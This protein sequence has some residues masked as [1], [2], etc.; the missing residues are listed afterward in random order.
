M[1]SLVLI[2]LLAIHHQGLTDETEPTEQPRVC[3]CPEE[4]PWPGHG[5]TN[6]NEQQL[7][8]KELMYMVPNTTCDKE[9]IYR[10]KVN[11]TIPDIKEKCRDSFC[12]PSSV[13]VCTT[14]KEPVDDHCLR[15]RFCHEERVM[16]RHMEYLYG[17]NWQK[18]FV[19]N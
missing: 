7:C 16:K 19:F 5:F 4:L 17:K 6:L 10:C 1:I 14:K 9:T 8:G 15:H 2:L 18:K 11:E 12:I 3:Q 13:K